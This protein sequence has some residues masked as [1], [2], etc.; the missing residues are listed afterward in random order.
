MFTHADLD[1]SPKISQLIQ[2]EF[3]YMFLWTFCARAHTHTHTH[4]YTHTHTNVHIS[5]YPITGL[6]MPLRLQESEAPTTSRQS[7]HE[8]GKVVSPTHR[9]PLSPIPLLVHKYITYVTV[10]VCVRVWCEFICVC[11]MCVYVC[12]GVDVCV[13]DVKRNCSLMSLYSNLIH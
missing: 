8:S 13:C 11:V 5:R 2:P 1:L 4:T 9:P 12:V 6:D 7:A 10:C 3:C